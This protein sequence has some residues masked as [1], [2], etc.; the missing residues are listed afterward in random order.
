MNEELCIDIE[1]YKLL[2]KVKTKLDPN[3]LFGT[4][5]E[6]ERVKKYSPYQYFYLITKYDGIPQLGGEEKER[7]SKDNQYHLEWVS[8]PEVA[9]IEDLYPKEAKNMLVEFIKEGKLNK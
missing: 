5:K 6:P 9:K 4:E 8:F 1:D 3:Y 7:S 2:F